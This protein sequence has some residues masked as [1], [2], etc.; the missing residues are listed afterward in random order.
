[1]LERR[2]TPQPGDRADV[3]RRRTWAGSPALGVLAGA[4]LLCV[5]TTAAALAAASYPAAGGAAQQCQSITTQSPSPGSTSSS[6][7]TTGSVPSPMST[8]ALATEACVS[9]QAVPGTVAPSDAAPFD[10]QVSP[11]GA[12]DQVTVQISVATPQPPSFAAP[13]FTSCGDGEGTQTCTAGVLQAGQASAMA[14]QVLVPAGAPGGDTATLSATVTWTVLGVVGTGSVTGSA[15]VDVTTS[16]A[17]SPANPSP[18]P[19]PSGGGHPGTPS[20]G[21]GHTRPPATGQPHGSHPAGS[22]TGSGLAA[23][24]LSHLPPLLRAGGTVAGSNPSGLF[25]VIRPSPLPSVSSSRA[26]KRPAAYHP[27]AVADILP[28]SVQLGYQVAGLTA[29]AIGVVMTVIRVPLARGR[30]RWARWR[31]GRSGTAGG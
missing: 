30:S 23:L 15:T 24:T 12:L 3:A 6:T 28:L 17:T 16:P 29:L 22:Q 10:I 31:H 21:H 20:P 26:G 14:A 8:S 5:G 1:M 13:T 27:T 25:P 7:P 11:V 19:T 4:A 2:F 9:V 18:S